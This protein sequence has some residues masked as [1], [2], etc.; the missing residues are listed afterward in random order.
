MVALVLPTFPQWSDGD[1]DDAANTNTFGP[2][3]NADRSAFIITATSALKFSQVYME[4]RLPPSTLFQPWYQ[5]TGASLSTSAWTLLDT[6]GTL[7]FGSNLWPH[8]ANPAPTYPPPPAGISQPQSGFSVNALDF[9]EIDVTGSIGVQSTA[10]ATDGVG[11]GLAATVDGTSIA[12]MVA[13]QTVGA[14]VASQPIV[15]PFHLHALV[16]FS[17]ATPFNEVFFGLAA[18]TTRATS[19]VSLSLYDSYV[20]TMKL[21]RPTGVPQ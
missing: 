15:V 13:S 11:I 17:F 20:M 7:S 12:A 16:E 5:V 10:G 18:L 8:T 19:A 2:T 4:E 9:V 14:S 3:P 1:D 21:W 6:V